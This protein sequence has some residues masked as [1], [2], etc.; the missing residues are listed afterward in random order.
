M[1]RMCWSVVSL[2]QFVLVLFFGFARGG[3][4]VKLKG[5]IINENQVSRFLCTKVQLLIENKCFFFS[6]KCPFEKMSGSQN[7]THS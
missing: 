1:L 5:L 3:K 7:Y 2:E 4:F 6:E